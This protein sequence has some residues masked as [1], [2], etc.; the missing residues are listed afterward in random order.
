MQYWKTHQ[1]SLI[2]E[3][4]EIVFEKQVKFTV[5]QQINDNRVTFDGE[6][7]QISKQICKI[8]LSTKSIN[9]D[10]FNPEKPF[11]CHIPGLDIILKKEKYSK[12]GPF[13]EFTVPSAIQ[14]YEKRRNKRYY[15]QYQDHKN[16]TFQSIAQ[17]NHTSKPDITFS[18]VLI[19][20]SVAGAGVAV[21]KDIIDKVQIG[22]IFY[23]VNLT[24][25]KLPEPFKIKIVY[26]EAYK[27]S[28]NDL[29]K[30]G[31]T[32]DD[33]LDSI[34][35]KSINSIIEIKQKKSQGLSGD[36]YCGLD[37]EEQINKINLIEGHNQ[38]LASNIKDN[39]EYLD[40]L[41]YMT[42]NMKVDFLKSVNNDL[43]AVALRLSSKELIY[44]LFSELTVTMQK[45]F[46]EKMQIEKPA[47]GVCKAQDEILKTIRSKE[48]NGEI[49][50][51]PTAFITYV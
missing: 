46:L 49:V 17:D 28:E 45:E 19:D 31:I 44:E 37:F 34:S 48:A 51:D 8:K 43:L 7:S 16:I 6:F 39:V 20:I 4:L 47:S 21:G 32:F 13:L 12:V 1:K 11:L 22:D 24:D 41:R 25:Q 14:V 29:Y 5:W 23:L 3:N 36:L 27:S 30:V 18:S 38:V 40:K 2:L 33:Q 35:Y 15:Y 50:L 10:R 42:T 9:Y 26:I